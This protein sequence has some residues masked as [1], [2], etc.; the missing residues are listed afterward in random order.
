MKAGGGYSLVVARNRAE[1][2]SVF[3]PVIED[4]GEAGHW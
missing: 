3:R 2:N 4:G 1:V